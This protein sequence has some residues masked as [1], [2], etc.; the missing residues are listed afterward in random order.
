[1]P[2][3]GRDHR[4]DAMEHGHVGHAAEMAH[5]IEAAAAKAAV[6]QFAQAALGDAVVDIGDGAKGSVAHGD[7][8]QRHPVVGAMHAGID[9]DGAA[10]PE[11]LV[12]R[13]EIP[14]GASG[15]V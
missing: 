7:G 1:M 11:F 5:E 8:V 15:G 3:Q 9:D 14:S 6:V 4:D 12:Q 13:P 10:D 2:A